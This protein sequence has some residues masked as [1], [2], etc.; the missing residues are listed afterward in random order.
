M[1]TLAERI[2]TAAHDN[3]DVSFR[4]SYSGRGMYGENC[5]GITGDTLEVNR[6]IAD[7]LEEMFDNVEVE[8]D[9]DARYNISEQMKK[10]MRTLLNYR[11]D[12]MGRDIICYWSKLQATEEMIE[13]QNNVNEQ[14]E[15]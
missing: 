8:T 11:Q 3:G 15:Y 7:V 4:T 2:Q 13:L 9:D 14:E 6:V 12:S 5:I 1:S 10:D